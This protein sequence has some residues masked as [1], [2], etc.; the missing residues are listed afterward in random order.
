MPQHG[1]WVLDGRDRRSACRQM[2][3]EDESLIERAL[4]QR[5]EVR[6]REDERTEADR[7]RERKAHREDIELGC[8]TGEYAER[9]VHHQH[10]DDWNHTGK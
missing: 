7:D 3:D 6:Q 4:E 9:E 10:G 2:G 1:Y 8:G 5:S